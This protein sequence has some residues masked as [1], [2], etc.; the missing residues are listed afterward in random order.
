MDRAAALAA[1]TDALAD[2]APEADLSAVPTDAD[3]AEELD[4]DSMDL[5]ELRSKL[6]ERTGVELP[7][8]PSGLASVDGILDALVA[9]SGG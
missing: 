1:L 9:G 6:H 4:L 3:L 8:D 5:L 7:D 2:V